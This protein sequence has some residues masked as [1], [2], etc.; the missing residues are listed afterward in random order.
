MGLYKRDD[1]PVWWASYSPAGKQYRVSGTTNKA[2]ANQFLAKQVSGQRIPDKESRKPNGFH[3]GEVAT[4]NRVQELAAAGMTATDIAKT[5]NLEGRN[6]RSG[7]EW[8]QPT[9]SKTL[10]RRKHSG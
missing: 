8:L 2:E 7:G 5:L 4:L 9:V 1:S 3:P 10:N 6:T